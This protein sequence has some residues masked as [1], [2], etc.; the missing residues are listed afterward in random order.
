MNL[1]ASSTSS[2]SSPTE[3]PTPL[4]VIAGQQ[5]TLM[6]VPLMRRMAS[7][8]AATNVGIGAGVRDVSKLQY[9]FTSGVQEQSD[10]KGEVREEVD[11]GVWFAEI[12][13]PGAGHNLMK[14]DG[15]ERCARILGRFLD[16]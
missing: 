7:M 11:A 1:L 2:S 15:W 8:Y 5:D 12:T 14:D 9:E 10:K 3:K 6:G 13:A 4:L 16:G